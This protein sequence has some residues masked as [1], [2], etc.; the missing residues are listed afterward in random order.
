LPTAYTV[1]ASIPVG[2]RLGANPPQA[3]SRSLP[4]KLATDP[5]SN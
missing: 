2:F 3:Q 1:L 4:A 5:Y